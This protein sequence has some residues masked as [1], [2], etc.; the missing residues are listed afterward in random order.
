MEVIN[1]SKKEF[2]NLKPLE[3]PKSVFNTEAKMYEFERR[4]KQYVL[5][6]LYNDGGPT[7]A[8]KLY[9]LEM[10]NTNRDFIPD[11]FILPENLVSVNQK[12]VGFT[13]PLMP[14][15]NLQEILNSPYIDRKEKI[16][17]LKR[18]GEILENIKNVRRYTRLTDFYIN[19]LHESNFL[20]NGQKKQLYVVD[21]D[22]CKIANNNVFC[23]RYLSPF[24][25][26]QKANTKKYS[27]IDSF[28]AGGYIMPDENSDLYCYSIILL[29]F[30]YRTNVNNM[31]LSE[32]YTYLTYLSDI[33][34]DKEL[35]DIFANLLT[36][37]QNQN[38]YHLLDTLSYEQIGK[39]SRNVFSLKM[40]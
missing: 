15:D 6:R 16:Y 9:T 38:P 22:S 33:G 28:S 30:L 31:N 4:R 25:L 10:L 29:N 40:N 26:F 19:D 3:L 39:A 2:G 8:N 17:Y 13:T 7:F 27:V 35:I 32:Y 23:S 18:I 20:V 12:V 24:S 14:G 34:I 5:K 11:S 36:A 21:T 37:K 1:L